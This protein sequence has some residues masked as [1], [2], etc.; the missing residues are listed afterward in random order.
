MEVGNENE[1][2]TT[3]K[4]ENVEEEKSRKF[5]EYPR[6]FQEYPNANQTNAQAQVAFKINKFVG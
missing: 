1:G 6:K 3:A 4:K 5:Q 2:D